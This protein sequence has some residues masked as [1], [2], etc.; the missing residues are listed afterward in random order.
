MSN[1]PMNRL[2]AYAFFAGIALLLLSPALDL[3]VANLARYYRDA[4]GV[5]AWAW[6]AYNLGLG[7]V[8][9][10]VCVL[11]WIWAKK[12][13]SKFHLRTAWAGASAVLASGLVSQ[14]LKHVI[15]RPRP[16]MNMSPFELTGY[17]ADADFHSMPSGHTAICFALAVIL[18]ARF[19]RHAWVFYAMAAWVGVG[20]VLGASHYLSDV[21]AAALLG[22]LVGLLLKKLFFKDQAGNAPMESQSGD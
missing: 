9:F 12:T 7:W 20:R 14:A 16:R 8:L 17:S 10:G 6:G 15:G 13:G 18:A 22:L 2:T 1:D 19:P 4:P 11:I 3:A 5:V 21:M